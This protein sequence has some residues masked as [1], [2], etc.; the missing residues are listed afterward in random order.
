MAPVVSHFSAV[1]CLGATLCVPGATTHTMPKARRR[2]TSSPYLVNLRREVY[3]VRRKGKVVSFKASYSGVIHIG[4]PV[5]QEFRVVFD[6]GSGHVIL[7]SVECRTETCQKHR[8]YN[9]AKSASAVAINMDGSPVPTEMNNMCDQVTIGFGTGKIT[10]EFVRDLVCLGPIVSEDSSGPHRGP[11]VNAQVVMAIEMSRRP[12]EL[13]DFDGI[14][15]LGLGSLALSSNFSFFGLLA[16]SD[17]VSRAHFGVFLADSDAGEESEIA[18]G[19]H[20]PR[21]L[22]EPLAWVPMAKPELGYW[23]VE[24]LALHIDGY[25]LDLC[26]ESTCSGILDTGTS[27]LGIP[28]T[29]SEQVNE[30]LTREADQV[31]DCRTTE[32]PIVRIELRDFNLT[33]Y[34]ENYMRKLPLPEDV[35][36]DTAVGVTSTSYQENLTDPVDLSDQHNGANPAK[37][38]AGLA[39][40]PAVD[41]NSSELLKH[42]CTPKLLPVNL[43]S[44]IGPNIFILGEPVLHRYYTVYDWGGL[45]AGFGLAAHLGRPRGPGISGAFGNLLAI[46]RKSA[47]ED[48]DGVQDDVILMQ[49]L[50]S[51]Q[52]FA[53]AKVKG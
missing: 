32:A 20:N 10:G 1:L 6:T 11:C 51:V 33:L 50:V 5:P 39:L 9:I 38:S 29:H 42:Y 23:Q 4:S 24:I 28:A 21:R 45:R 15:G 49:I 48:V 34:P 22:L 13:F 19:G 7:P 44:P 35:N 31:T 41:G 26:R 18:I 27:H 52:L 16:E 8:R 30:L 37:V 36:V 14:L 3:P 53:G 43:S 47:Q 25:K 46:P 12:F 2:S 40:P 17:Q